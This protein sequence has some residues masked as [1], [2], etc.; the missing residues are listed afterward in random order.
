MHQ[1]PPFSHPFIKTVIDVIV[2]KG[3]PAPAKHD[4]GKFNPIPLE[5]IAYACTMGYFALKNVL[6]EDRSVFAGEDYAPIFDGFVSALNTFQVEDPKL[7]EDLR[8]KLSKPRKA[9]IADNG[10]SAAGTMNGMTRS[11]S[12]ADIAAELERRRQ[13]APQITVQGSQNV[14]ISTS[15]QSNS[16]ISAP[17]TG[18][19]L[20]HG[21]PHPHYPTPYP[22][23][24]Q[25]HGGP[26]VYQALSGINSGPAPPVAGPP[27][28][29][30]SGATP[31]QE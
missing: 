17:V 12:D 19:P 10:H 3:R 20:H 30:L 5:T 4:P 22:V 9:N 24:Y 1:K 8:L 27:V 16:S 31:S 25:Y 11:L 15:I 26:N 13:I 7:F 14:A 28:A 29:G 2:F 6:A 23:P 21:Y 18:I